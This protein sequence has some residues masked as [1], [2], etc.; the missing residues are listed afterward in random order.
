MDNK[1]TS[2]L[3]EQEQL[4]F[5]MS[6]TLVA[7]FLE[8]YDKA[9][10]KQLEFAIYLSESNDTT[11]QELYQHIVEDYLYADHVDFN[12]YIKDLD[13]ITCATKDDIFENVSRK[14]LA[15]E[16]TGMV[17]IGYRTALGMLLNLKHVLGI[18]RNS[19]KSEYRKGHR[20]TIKKMWR[21]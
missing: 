2:I 7:N 8:Q 1:L 10:L 6:K 13:D 4:L 21:F 9:I 11:H 5:Q 20:A 14:W 18:R 3:S 12:F 19:S 17:W 15:Q 16:T